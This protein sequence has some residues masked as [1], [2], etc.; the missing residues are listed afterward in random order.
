MVLGWGLEAG[1]SL[2]ISNRIIDLLRLKNL[3]LKKLSDVILFLCFGY[4]SETA[5]S[6]LNYWHYNFQLQAYPAI[7]IFGYVF[8]GILVSCCGREF[9]SL[10]DNKPDKK[11]CI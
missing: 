10:I 2:T 4:A 6:K 9:Q 7:Q 3:W 1:L 11:T 5:M 8:V